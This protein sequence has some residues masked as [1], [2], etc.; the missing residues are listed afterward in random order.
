MLAVLL[1]PPRGAS[2][3]QSAS[4]LWPPRF[5]RAGR[6]HA[7]IAI[8]DAF[9]SYGINTGSAGQGGDGTI[10]ISDPFTVTTGASV[11]VVEFDVYSNTPTGNDG[12]SGVGTQFSSTS[13]PPTGASPAITATWVSPT[14]SFTTQ[15]FATAIQ[16]VSYAG[17]HITTDILYIA[18]PTRRR[19]QYYDYMPRRAHRLARRDDALRRQYPTGGAAPV[20]EQQRLHP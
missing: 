7:V 8:Q 9:Q 16:Q 20:G 6:A 13:S 1:G 4:P 17:T 12:T 2:P 10:S 19:R 14:S 11:L 18:N 15:T 3:G 5:R